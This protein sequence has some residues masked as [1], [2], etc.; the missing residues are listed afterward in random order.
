MAKKTSSKPPA[1]AEPL[2]SPRYSAFRMS[3]EQVERDLVAGRNAG[4]LKEYFSEPVYEELRGLARDSSRAV[5]GG[6]RVY[7]LPGIMGS[8]IGRPDDVIWIDPFDIRRGRLTSL[9]VNGTNRLVSLGVIP[10]AYMTIKLR[11]RW[12]GLDADFFDY[13]W[14]LGMNELGAQLARQI[15]SDPARK[16]SIVAHSMGG[17]VARA[18]LARTDKIDRLI[19]LGTPNQGSF[20]PIQ[21]IRGTYSLLQR[22]AALDGKNTTE[23]L[24]RKVVIT[25]PGLCQ[26]LPWPE[27]FSEVDL[28]DEDAWPPGRPVPP[29]SLLTQA[30]KVQSSLPGGDDRFTLIAGVDQ[31]TVT[32]VRVE[33]SEF[34]E[35]RTRAGDGTV[36][37][38]L[39]QLDGVPTYYV[40]EDHGSLQNNR[41]VAA[42]V[43]DLLQQGRTEELPQQWSVP[44]AVAVYETR[45][46]DAPRPDGWGALPLPPG[47]GGLDTALPKAANGRPRRTAESTEPTLDIETASS[48]D[49]RNI[50]SEVA[51]PPAPEPVSLVI[52]QPDQSLRNIVVGRRTQHRIDIRLAHGSI[53]E[54][55]TRAVV[56][57][58]FRDVAPSGPAL[59]LNALLDNAI[60][61]FTR[62]RM[63]SAN[64]G[65]VFIMPALRNRLRT[66][67]VL[68][69]GLGSF[70]RMSDSV[71]QLVA[72]NTIRTFI[73]TGV[74]EFATVLFGSG[75]GAEI[76]QTLENLLQGFVRGLLD[77]DSDRRF[78]GITICELDDQRYRTIRRE[79]YRLASSSLFGSL[80]VTF[81]ET[82]LPPPVAMPQVA[83]AAAGQL[84]RD[85]VYLILRREDQP[86][87]AR[88]TDGSVANSSLSG[89]TSES[90]T[91]RAERQ[92]ALHTSLLT[93]GGK[94][95]V[96]Q[97]IKQVD[98]R[99]L[100][101]HL[102]RI[103]STAFNFASVPAFG[104]ELGRMVLPR[105]ILS[106]LKN[107]ADH[108]LVIVNDAITSRIPWETLHLDDWAPAAEQG[109]T[110]RYL[111]ENMSVAKWLEERRQGPRL[112]LLLIVNPTGDLPGAEKEG[113]RIRAYVQQNP[114][115]ELTELARNQ[116]THQRLKAEFSSGKYDAVHYAGH[117]FFDSEQRSRSGILCADRR[118]L[119]GAD[120]AALSHLPSLVFFNACEAARVRGRVR[121]QR[122]TPTIQERIHRNV[123]FAEAYLRGGVANFIGTY[124]PVGDE[125]AEQFADSFYRDIL[126]GK[127]LDECLGNARRMIKES[128][129]VDW[130][131][132][133]HYGDPGFQ[134]KI[135]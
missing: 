111:A 127:S 7:V 21:A 69:A 36:P 87:A 90:S 70:D 30:R 15:E 106:A 99:E 105:S 2:E 32:G 71:Q 104:R 132:Y 118:V 114:S 74:E 37:L 101:A 11:L 81:D 19:M 113:D 12:A 77:T 23:E 88:Q 61:E 83:R 60:V 47:M 82:E 73:R 103:E 1:I 80:E 35:R 4:L 133:I 59:A 120:L 125:A 20:M 129:S 41:R 5:R 8:Q 122:P 78:R 10:L 110:R 27:K 9:A 38:A 121:N 100:D 126:E 42:A 98:H 93:A 6:Q 51:A 48:S 119:S 108:H 75:S 123:S 33:G 58:V 39:A 22:I 134:L 72:E 31:Y 24:A 45:E 49:L 34:I 50:I 16:I 28:F 52:N 46:S 65:E 130:A 3:A 25:W 135:V 117:A 131:D 62:R 29:Q 116:A 63:F 79:L 112:S 68:F 89:P 102:K 14:R 17:L 95:T 40:E 94:A 92:F 55:N 124:W 84:S 44:R 115:I 109:L 76:G 43:I 91:S 66:E 54:V 56:L 96:I 13:D 57:G 67:M 107:L 64:V 97:D 128:K 53:T 18:A 26:L 86:D 85:P